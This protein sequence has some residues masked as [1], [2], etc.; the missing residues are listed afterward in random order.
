[1]NTL[2]L[3]KSTKMKIVHFNSYGSTD[4]LE[5]GE[6]EKP[7]PK[8]NEVLIKVKATTVTAGDCEL[9]AFKITPLFWL[10][11]RLYFGVFKPRI[12][13]LGQELAGEIEAVGKDVTTFKVGDA[14]FAGTGGRVGT[15]LEY[16]C[17]RVTQSI[18]LKPKNM[19]FEE[20]A[21]IPTGG[22]NALYFMEKASI[23]AG[24]SILINGAGG[25]IGTYALQMAKSLGGIV[26]AV[27][28]GRK[29]DMLK[30]IGADEVIDYK[31]QDFTKMG[32]TYD[33]IFDVAGKCKYS[34]TVKALKENGRYVQSNPSL[35]VMFRGLWTKWTTSKRVLTGLAGEGLEELA[36]LKDMIEAGKL[37]S[38]ID[39]RFRLEDIVAAQQYVEAGHKSGNV[40]VIVS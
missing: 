15:Y 5:L 14:V 31:Q 36:K 28:T 12:P 23:K 8:D 34:P 16:K 17:Q 2:K 18:A 21:T 13:T 6:T 29:L 19:S 3:M 39:K 37:K 33:V 30:S 22:L 38:V 10:P 25:S 9:R 40:V 26:T 32:K 24:E 4:V 1:M 7:E 35:E 20:A 11:V 27:D